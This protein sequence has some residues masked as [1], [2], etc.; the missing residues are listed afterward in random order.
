MK[1][2]FLKA[3]ALAACIGLV[4]THTLAQDR[5][6]APGGNNDEII[7]R[8]K[9]D[10]DTKVTLEIHGDD[11]IV[12]GKPLSDFEDENIVI[13]KRR[14][15]DGL[16]RTY[17]PYPPP[18]PR[19]PFRGGT[20]NLD[21]NDVFRAYGNLNKALLGVAS[22]KD[23]NGVKVTSITKG[24]A[25][26][27]AGLKEGDVITRVDDANIQNPEDL[28]K[29]IGKYKPDDKVTIAYKRDKKEM[30]ATATLGKRSGAVSIP[31]LSDMSNF[32]RDFNFNFD[33]HGENGYN[34]IMRSNNPRIGIKAQD[35][36]DG[37]GVKVLD[38]DDGS[39]AQKAGIKQDDVVTEF[40]GKA[41]NSAADLA[42]A[43][44]DAKDKI[45]VKVKLT[46][47][48]KSQE[49]EIKIPRKLKTATL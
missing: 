48:G 38:V 14:A 12:N 30:K 8:K 42:E 36:E 22:A 7:I 46:R 17:T 31:N 20:M 28:T 11:V 27:K 41:V 49:A 29:V 23:E 44:R 16:E 15:A 6:V 35:T 5:T 19:S 9:G 39:N 1:Q 4:S 32:E 21:N 25:A 34:L 33:N 37:K 18:P 10:K 26:E 45:S 47:N 24:S 13:R 3:I 40:D 2:Y 43:A